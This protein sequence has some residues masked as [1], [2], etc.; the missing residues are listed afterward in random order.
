ML[1][2][3]AFDLDGT[4]F[5]SN[6][7][8][9]KTNIVALQRLCGNGVGI[10]IASGRPYQVVKQVISQLKLPVEG[11]YCIT[12][13]GARVVRCCD[14][15]DI[16]CTTIT[17]SDV[18]RIASF[19]FEHGAFIHAFSLERGLLLSKNNP[20]SAKE[21]FNGLVTYRE[22]DFM[23][24]PDDELF[25]KTLIAA[26][27]QVLDQ[28]AQQLPEEFYARYR[29]VRSL[30]TLMEFLEPNTCKGY[31][32]EQLSRILGL[33]SSEIIAFGDELNDL[34]MLKF[35]GVGVAMANGS[36]DLMEQADFVTKS[37][38]EDGVAYGLS[39][40]FSFSDLSI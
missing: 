17:G 23:S 20:Y 3:A 22:A 18:K 8:I 5:N 34:E 15:R 1:K 36:R 39:K 11:S 40:Y 14:D 24:F 29:V 28:L 38:D 25:Y 13:N 9:S 19:A 27:P 33:D 7:E 26:N 12:M 2:L 16:S 32:L 21:F 6:S 10:V 35:A 30:R 31:A 37:N 4:L